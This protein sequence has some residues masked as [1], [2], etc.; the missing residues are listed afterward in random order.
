MKTH[1]SQ[2]KDA[3]P[4]ASGVLG[5]KTVKDGVNSAQVA[6]VD[7]TAKNAAQNKDN[8]SMS[9]QSQ[10]TSSLLETSEDEEAKKRAE[11][12][13][14]KKNKKGL[15]DKEIEAI[16]DIELCE[17]ETFDLLFI[18][19]TWVMNDTDEHTIVTAENKK[20]QDLINNKIGSDSYTERGSQTLNLTH[21]PKEIHYK[22]FQ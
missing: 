22:G 2:A 7:N 1:Q 20:Y 19:S 14:A 15:S 4:G 11:E 6:T 18:P 8:T 10:L 13:L 9:M 12:K 16:I 5:E 17:S 3:Q 21:K